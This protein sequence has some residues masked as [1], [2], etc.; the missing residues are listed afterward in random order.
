MVAL[1]LINISNGNNNDGTDIHN[2]GGWNCD[3][4]T[5]NG[6]NCNNCGDGSIN[7]VVVIVIITIMVVMVTLML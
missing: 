2:N 1:I 4:D 6:N 7:A 3:N 5:D